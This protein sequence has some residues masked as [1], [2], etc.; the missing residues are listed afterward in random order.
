ML[1]SLTKDAKSTKELVSLILTNF[2]F[3]FA[4]EAFK[5][6]MTNIFG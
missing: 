4:K 5:L 6:I 1:R 3:D 2:R